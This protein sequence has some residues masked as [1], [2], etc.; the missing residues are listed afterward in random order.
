MYYIQYVLG[1]K[2][3][4]SFETGLRVAIEFIAQGKSFFFKEYNWNPEYHDISIIEF[5]SEAHE[6]LLIDDRGVL[7]QYTAE[8]ALNRLLVALWAK[9]T[10]T[11]T[12]ENDEIELPLLDFEKGTSKFEVWQWFESVGFEKH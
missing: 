7:E 6:V 10:D 3:F 1:K 12:N 2:E 8:N 5:N 4:E 9:L 11:P